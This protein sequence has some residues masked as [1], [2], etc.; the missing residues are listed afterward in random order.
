MKFLSNKYFKILAVISILLV[1]GFLRLYRITDLTIWEGDQGSDFLVAQQIL[2]GQSQ[3]LVGP[4]LNV[5]NFY[6][7]PTYYYLLA[8]FLGIVKTPLYVAILFAGL[9]IIAG[10]FIFLLIGRLFDFV[11]G[12]FSLVLFSLSSVMIMNAQSVY[13]PHPVIFFITASWYLLWEAWRKK[14]LALLTISNAIFIIGASIYPAPWLL[15]PYFFV[16]NVQLIRRS[17]SRTKNSYTIIV[18]VM[19]IG[20]IVYFPQI[21]FEVS[22]GYPMTKTIL[23]SALG[24]PFDLTFISDYIIYFEQ[25]ILQFFNLDNIITPHQIPFVSSALISLFILTIILS[26]RTVKTLRL[27]IRHA[28]QTVWTFM[29]PLW[30]C[31]CFIPVVFFWEN[32]FHRLNVYYP[33]LLIMFVVCAKIA[34]VGHSWLLKYI[35]ILLFCVYCFGALASYHTTLANHTISEYKETETIADFILQDSR[36]RKLSN[37]F[38]VFYY[39]PYGYGNYNAPAV[40]YFLQQESSYHPQFLSPYWTDKS[41]VNSATTDAAYLICRYYETIEDIMSRCRN[42]FLLW[43]PLYHVAEEKIFPLEQL[44]ILTKTP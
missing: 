10:I 41:T 27:N 40:F 13:Q 11:T 39:T 32:A 34:Y 18:S 26:R 1:S 3:T 38:G 7:P 8:L 43:N 15:A 23:H 6:T 28:Y 21:I 33:L 37:S 17:A 16:K 9:N 35:V 44:F 12:V 30:L 5:T 22:H 36:K 25:I 2:H 29:N 19:F 42:M 31:V 14:N 20:L 4:P 24:I